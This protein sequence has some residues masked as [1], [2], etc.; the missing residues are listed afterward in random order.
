MSRIL[1]RFFVLL[2]LI[3]SCPL[4]SVQAQG[5]TPLQ[6][7]DDGELS[8]SYPADWM[9]IPKGSAV[10]LTSVKAS[11]RDTPDKQ[12]VIYVSI[13]KPSVDTLAITPHGVPPGADLSFLVG[14]VATANNT[15]LFQS[16]W[17]FEN[18]DS[19]T[20]AD[21]ETFFATARGASVTGVKI[22]TDV[23]VIDTGVGR[24][25]IIVV[26]DASDYAEWGVTIRALIESVRYRPQDMPE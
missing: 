18:V 6:R 9:V 14:Y 15:L 5:D 1:S 16:E 8:F 17:V 23:G 3:A 20:I 2:I 10:L 4:G 25:W 13:S 26:A 24:L 21:Y 12:V 22:V 7:F 11:L 19:P